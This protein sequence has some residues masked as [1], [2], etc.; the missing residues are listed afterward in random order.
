MDADTAKAI[1]SAKERKQA[2]SRARQTIYNRKKALEPGY[3]E[4]A[5]A[6]QR[7]YVARMTPEQHEHQLEYLRQYRLR[8]KAEVAEA[9]KVLAAAAD[10]RVLT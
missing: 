9:T 6:R 10:A 7:D 5:R 4:A 8:K 3:H 2:A 1:L